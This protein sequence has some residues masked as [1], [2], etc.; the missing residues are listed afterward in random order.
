V[1]NHVIANGEPSVFIL[2]FG[3]LWEIAEFAGGA[4]G[5]ALTSQ[6][7][8][9]QYGIGDIVSDLVFNTIAAVVVA[10]WGTGYFEDVAA[11]LTERVS[12]TED[13]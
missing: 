12:G 10:I 9:V 7:V 1:R 6:E 3:V 13:S 5:K 8:L 2:A 11:I 4:V